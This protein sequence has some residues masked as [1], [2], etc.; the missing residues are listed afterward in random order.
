MRRIAM[1]I[2][3]FV[4]ALSMNIA[5]E[6]VFA[7]SS[8]IYKEYYVDISKGDDADDG[9]ALAPFKTVE[10]AVEAVRDVNSDMTGDI[11]VN[12]ASGR[13]E[14]S[15]SVDFK[16]E[17]SGKNGHR[18]IYRGIGDDKPVFSGAKKIEGF[19]VND[20]GIWSVH[21]DAEYIRELCVNGVMA[22]IARSENKIY[23]V[24]PYN[25]VYTDG[26]MTE[27][28]GIYISKSD[29]D[30]YEN[31]SDIGFKWDFAHT[32]ALIKVSD[33]IQ[34]PDNE[35]RV[36]AK[37][38]KPVWNSVCAK[39][40]NDISIALLSPGW[41]CAFSVENAYELMDMPGEFYYN[42][43]EKILY[44]YP[45]E[46]ED[47][48]TAE[49]LCPQNDK[50][51]TV[52]GK[53]YFNKA[54]NISFENIKFAH[55]TWDY[56]DD[57]SI[58]FF[59][60]E[61]PQVSYAGEATTPGAFEVD[62]TNG[63]NICCCDFYGITT[64]A[65]K[66][67]DGV[68][69][70]KIEGNTFSDIGCGAVLV[71]AKQHSSFSVPASVLSGKA[72]VFFKKGWSSSSEP[73]FKAQLINYQY[74]AENSGSNYTWTNEYE[75]SQ[76]SEALSWVKADLGKP[77]DISRI[78]IQ[79][80]NT[81]GD[82]HTFTTQEKSNFEILVSND[83]TFKTYK[84]VKTYATNA[85]E[86]LSVSENYT[87]KYRYVMFRKTIAEPF[88]V[89]CFWIYSEDEEPQDT[90]IMGLCSDNTISNNYIT[91]VGKL[92][93]GAPAITAYYT[94]RLTV[95]NNE[96]SDIPYSGI[97]LGWG[98]AVANSTAK[99][100]VV[101]NNYIHDYMQMCNDGGGIYVLGK[102]P[103]T[104]I[105]GNYF[106]NGLN[107]Y[108]A[109]YFDTGSVGYSANNNVADNTNSAVFQIDG[110][111][112]SDLSIKNTYAAFDTVEPYKSSV[113]SSD[114]NYPI[115]KA[116]IANAL[117]SE[118]DDLTVMQPNAYLPEAYDI[119]L[120]A[121]LEDKYADIVQ[122]VPDN[123]DG[124]YKGPYASY[125]NG[126]KSQRMFADFTNAYKRT[127][128]YQ[129]QLLNILENGSFGTE[130]WQYSPEDKYYITKILNRA[131][132][133]Y[134]LKALGSSKPSGYW[135]RGVHIDEM[136]MMKALVERLDASVKHLSADEMIALCDTY[137]SE[138]E[139]G[140]DFGKYK[141]GAK[142]ELQNVL[143]NVKFLERNTEAERYR[144][145]FTLEKALNKFAEQK[146]SDEIIG[147]YVDE[148]K[149]QIDAQNKTV[150]IKLPFGAD[151]NDIEPNFTVSG[152]ST[153]TV[154]DNLEIGKR[155][156]LT[157][158]NSDIQKTNNEWRLILKDGHSALQVLDSITESADEWF[159]ANDNAKIIHS[160][161]ELAF[162]PYLYPYMY[163]KPTSGTISFDV[164]AS[165]ADYDYGISFIISAKVCEDLEYDAKSDSKNTYYMLSLID[166]SL[167]LYR[168]QS[169]N[170][171]LVCECDD[172][173]FDYSNY[174][175]FSVI[176]TTQNNKDYFTVKIN[177]KTVLN[178]V[179]A[180]SIGCEGYFGVL[181]KSVPLKIKSESYLKASVTS[182]KKYIDIKAAESEDNYKLLT[183]FYDENDLLISIEEAD[184]NL[185]KNKRYY[186]PKKTE[187]VVIF[188]MDFSGGAMKPVCCQKEIYIN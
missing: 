107:G 44:Y 40:D 96:I 172:V 97:S 66:L 181:T 111:T 178:N 42:K 168:V 49:V 6:E 45:R 31:P 124:L 79:F 138:A 152:N 159:T 47:P 117:N 156:S 54:E 68:I 136:Y 27:M 94:E 105:N 13:Y 110:N 32:S 2:L 137:L 73:A 122:N 37:F 184:K 101:S 28:D 61:S 109:L 46:G 52:S 74:N 84:T 100:N 143:D 129:A 108:G 134:N 171:T 147:A 127:Y 24:G 119:V 18:V 91:R 98:F 23:G 115:R 153:V 164:K 72:N 135:C 167:K 62:W 3:T 142:D 8:D 183:A 85:S 188:L 71:G 48:Q 65:L 93:S 33:L 145:V 87:E 35:S 75:L 132:N 60:A 128:Y 114:P 15:H 180:G 116:L 36:I 64:A 77:Y 176:P 80:K 118:V 131:D 34:D 125:G 89:T 41:Q 51:I 186:I 102:N 113:S 50:L 29:I 177:G 148:G 1:L 5:F 43:S 112:S 126:R 130:K 21:I 7:V 58:Y 174:N 88:A 170:T 158:Y 55:T 120:N 9:S 173:G 92:H 82:S 22:Q 123:S 56:L 104:T 146:Y 151:L 155:L 144:I 166:K 30:L 16:V 57:Y 25:P 106:K 121:G 103:G 4:T 161:N 38:N 19:T 182:D 63:L 149:V 69:N 53:G 78:K 185:D 187:K 179:E 86:S 160:N 99:D 154:T 163:K 20:D 67:H 12:I 140:S 169:G 17:D 141:A 11:I 139:E 14:L 59:Q 39:D 10:R 157:V 165:R 150:E 162:Q 76:N 175:S 90:Y 81:G 26:T 83:R 95:S 70:S 133:P